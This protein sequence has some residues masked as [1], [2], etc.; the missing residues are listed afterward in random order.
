MVNISFQRE[1]RISKNP[2]KMWLGI[3]CLLVGIFLTLVY[4]N[5]IPSQEASFDY[6][7]LP[8]LF[9][10]LAFVIAGGYSI[11]YNLNKK[12]AKSPFSKVVF[13]TFSMFLLIPFH[14]IIYQNYLRAG[15]F[16]EFIFGNFGITLIVTL[17]DLI[18]IYALIYFSYKKLKEKNRQFS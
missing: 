11:L 16:H 10:S 4:F 3:L 13:I 15:S 17:F 14:I 2:P 1:P 18:F 8:V 9:I 6:G 5:I 12:I 7:R